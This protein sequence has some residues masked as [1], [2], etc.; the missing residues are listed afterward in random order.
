MLLGQNY[1]LALLSG[2]VAERLAQNR[3]VGW[4]LFGLLLVF[5]IAS[6]GLFRSAFLPKPEEHLHLFDR[7]LRLIGAMILSIP[8]IVGIIMVI[9]ECRS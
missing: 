9:L 1:A 6:V 2:N 8:P 7:V 4:M 5:G 3:R